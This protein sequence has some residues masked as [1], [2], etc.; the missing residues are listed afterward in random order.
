MSDQPAAPAM[1]Q[2]RALV[3]LRAT[4]AFSHHASANIP[5]LHGKLEL[6]TRPMASPQYS[7]AFAARSY[8]VWSIIF[9]GLLRTVLTN[10]LGAT[11][12]RRWPRTDVSSIRADCCLKQ[13]KPHDPESKW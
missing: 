12:E 4:T 11:V 6:T 7:T 5:Q 2:N 10:R 1:G 8:H 3:W 13:A 9:P